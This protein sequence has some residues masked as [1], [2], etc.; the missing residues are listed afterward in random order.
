[1]SPFRVCREIGW[2]LRID[3]DRTTVSGAF[4]FI[5]LIHL[6]R[7]DR[8]MVKNMGRIERTMTMDNDWPCI[9]AQA[10]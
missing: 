5:H 8:W 2:T 9:G 7:K 3:N 6:N 10:P 1:M 4:P